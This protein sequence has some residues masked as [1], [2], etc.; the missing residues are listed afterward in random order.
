MT[1]V[2]IMKNATAQ[3]THK[4]SKRDKLTCESISGFA[5]D[6]TTRISADRHARWTHNTNWKPLHSQ[7]LQTGKILIL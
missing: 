2:V 5:L 4:S 1:S 7:T 6:Q 3:P